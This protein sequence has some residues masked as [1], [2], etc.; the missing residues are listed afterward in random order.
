MRIVLFLI[1]WECHFM[2]RWV[3]RCTEQN[4]LL[5]FLIIYKLWSLHIFYASSLTTSNHIE[6]NR[7]WQKW[8]MYEIYIMNE[9]Y[10][11]NDI[12][13]YVCVCVGRI[14]GLIPHHSVHIT[15]LWFVLHKCFDNLFS[16]PY[17]IG[18]VGYSLIAHIK[19][20][21]GILRHIFVSNVLENPFDL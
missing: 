5:G 13:I 1:K 14:Q 11:K 15:D 7:R 18:T 8:Y 6:D 21:H 2:N 17:I 9:I 4:A 19:T 10:M 12:Y 3:K 16:K 20:G